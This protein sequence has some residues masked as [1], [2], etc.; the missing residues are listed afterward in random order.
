MNIDITPHHPMPGPSADGA[1]GGMGWGG[2]ISIFIL[3]SIL[4]LILIALLILECQCSKHI[5]AEKKKSNK[6]R[7]AKQNSVFGSAKSIRIQP[8]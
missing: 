6:C 2:V 3:I 4:I 8:K 1:G 5:F 7:N